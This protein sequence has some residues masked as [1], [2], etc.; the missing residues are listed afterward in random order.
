MAGVFQV[1]WGQADGTFKKATTLHGTDDKPLVIPAEGEQG[2][3]QAICTRPFAVDWDGDGDLDLVVGNFAGSFYL[4]T[5]EGQGKFRPTP[6]RILAGGEP[7]VVPGHHGDPFVVDWDGDGDLD[8]LSGADAGGVHWAENT[9]GR[10]KPPVLKKFAALIAPDKDMK[11]ECRP[12]EV[13][14]PAGS[15]RVWVA[16]VNADGKLDILVGDCISLQSPAKGVSEEE[17]ASRL[18][19]WRADLDAI[20]QEMNA[21]ASQPA[22][23]SGEDGAVSETGEDPFAPFYARMNEL[24]A[25]R[26]EFMH[27]ERTGF[28]WVYLQKAK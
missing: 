19:K 2:I 3:I 16:D 21:A 6:D 23:Q 22:N 18:A 7:L 1:L 28:V 15:T 27:E 8:L 26:K 24:Y 20:Q 4:F 14:L 10:G 5:G 25:K 13:S 11:R 9:A 17:F 12:E